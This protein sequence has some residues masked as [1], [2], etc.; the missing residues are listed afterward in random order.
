MT[1]PFFAY[2]NFGTKFLFDTADDRIIINFDSFS[3]SANLGANAV[4]TL[5]T[6]GGTDYQVPTGKELI[7]IGATDLHASI[8]DNLD[9]CHTTAVNADT[10]IVIDIANLPSVN[11]NKWN[12]LF[13]KMPADS[14]PGIHESLGLINRNFTTVGLQGVEYTPT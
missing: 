2:N 9:L 5:E 10:G 11:P 4:R 1:D 6:N 3:P 12:G 13:I 8:S 7:L 14:F